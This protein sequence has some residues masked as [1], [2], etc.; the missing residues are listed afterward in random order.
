MEVLLG[1]AVFSLANTTGPVNILGFQ[2][3]GDLTATGEV[4]NTNAV[5]NLRAAALGRTAVIT[6]LNDFNLLASNLAGKHVL[7]IY[8]MEVGGPNGVTIGTAWRNDLRKF[9][10]R[11]GVIIGLDFSTQAFQILN[12]AGL[13]TVTGTTFASGSVTVAL[14]TDPVGVGVVSPYAAA[15]GT[16]GFITTEPTTSHVVVSGVTPVVIHKVWP[17][18][19]IGQD[20][21]YTACFEPSGAST[22]CADVGAGTPTCQ[23]ADCTTMATIPFP[24]SFYGSASTTATIMA[25]GKI[26]FPGTN[27][28]ENACVI[29]NNTI[30]AHWDDLDA[31]AGGGA[32]GNRYAVTGVAPNRRFNV[33]WKTP[34]SSIGAGDNLDIRA[35][36]E[37]GT[38]IINV[39]YVDTAAGASYASAGEA[40]VGI[41]GS[42]A[43][44]SLLL[45]CD[46]PLFPN[47]TVVR[48]TPN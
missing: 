2:Q 35:Q 33:H 36:I 23:T 8:E 32:G 30:A 6:P 47:G 17:C 40:T 4:A 48:F 18:G 21:S 10:N 15:S 5:I 42:D 39:C 20:N 7:V 31:S 24:F 34:P 19:V 38:G 3:Y 13:V 44:E 27:D 1:N 28:A 37:E 9:L 41:A 26:G 25:H 45:S 16:S 11:G 29:E 12:T 14:P 46:A 43:G 22:V